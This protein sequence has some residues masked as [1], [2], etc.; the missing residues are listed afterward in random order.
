MIG[1]GRRRE[2]PVIAREALLDYATEQRLVARSRDL[3]VAGKARR[4]AIDSAA[5]A[6]RMGLERHEVGEFTLGAADRFSNDH[7]GVVR[8]LCHQSTNRVLNLDG[9]PGLE[10]ELRGS[11]YG[12]VLGHRKLRI[13]PDLAGIEPLKKQIEGHDLGERSRMAQ[14]VCLVGMEH[15]AGIGI[16]HDCRVGRGGG[17]FMFGLPRFMVGAV[18]RAMAR[19]GRMN[20]DRN[21]ESTTSVGGQPSALCRMICS[22][23]WSPVSQSGNYSQVALWKK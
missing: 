3:L 17:G 1:E 10:A 18:P 23:L 6:D 14:L 5:H 4:V 7:R 8:G 11:L 20:R 2:I 13:E 19:G 22:Q 16:H 9:L 15:N 21:D 12:G